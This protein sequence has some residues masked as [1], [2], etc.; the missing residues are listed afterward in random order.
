MQLFI[1]KETPRQFIKFSIVGLSNTLIDIGIFQALI[2]YTPIYYVV[3][4]IISFLFGVLNSYIWNRV[5]TFKSPN[6]KIGKEFTRFVIISMVGLALNTLFLV[7]FME[8]FDFPSFLGKVLATILVL[9]W[10]FFMSKFWA[11]EVYE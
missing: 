5:W 9:I 6:K 3:A 11:F 8:V 4:N 7:V 10:N 2:A 1:K